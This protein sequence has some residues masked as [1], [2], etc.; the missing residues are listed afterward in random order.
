M[1][2]YIQQPRIFNPAASY[3]AGALARNRFDTGQQ[4]Q[5]INAFNL[6]RSKE[7]APII[8]EKDRVQIQGLRQSLSN[9]QFQLAAKKSKQLHAGLRAYWESD[10]KEANYPFL[11]QL[12]VRQGIP[13]EHLPVNYDE[14]AIKKHLL[15]SGLVA[16]EFEKYNNKPMAVTMPDGSQG[17]VQ[18]GDQGSMRP[19]RGGYTPPPQKEGMSIETPDG[20]KIRFGKY[21]EPA[22][23]GAQTGLFKDVVNA[24]KSLD[25]IR[26]IETLYE[27]EFLTYGGAAKGKVATFLNK[28]DASQRSQFQ[29]RRAKFISLAN[30]EF[31][32]FRKWATG[33]AGGEKEMA[34]IKRATFS[35]DDS[36]QDFET[37]MQGVKSLRRRLIA[38]STAALKAGINN[39]ADFKRYLKD[40]PLGNIPTIQQRGDQLESEGY[41]K[42]QIIGI[43]IDEGYIDSGQQK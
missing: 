14:E 32:A 5:Q 19:M 7:R 15:Q 17:Y 10:D 22:P 43:L 8:D 9:D 34:E 26:Q 2:N 41:E 3:Q 23:K 37:K 31:L 35:E 24:Q 29:G 38:R 21:G 13:E 1:A 20:T 6:Q 28:M 18:A 36:P 33:V 16:G 11:K 25:S 4:N 27:P 30:Q 12:L 40:N 42:E 39:Q